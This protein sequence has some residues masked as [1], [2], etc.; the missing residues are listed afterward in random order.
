V[1]QRGVFLP[2]TLVKPDIGVSNH[3]PQVE[4]QKASLAGGAAVDDDFLVGGDA[5]G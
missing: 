5:R 2:G 1:L 4:P 3:M